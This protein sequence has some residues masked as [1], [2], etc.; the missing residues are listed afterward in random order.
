[1]ANIQKAMIFFFQSQRTRKD[2]RFEKKS[3]LYE[4]MAKRYDQLKFFRYKNFD[5]S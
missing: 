3:P 1:M 5:R 4:F 2:N